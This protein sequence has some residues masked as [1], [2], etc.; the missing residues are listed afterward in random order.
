MNRLLMFSCNAVAGGELHDHAQGVQMWCIMQILAG[1]RRFAD[2]SRHRSVMNDVAAVA[3]QSF[4]L[5]L[6]QAGCDRADCAVPR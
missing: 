2:V 6:A 3:R 1:K 5:G 4:M